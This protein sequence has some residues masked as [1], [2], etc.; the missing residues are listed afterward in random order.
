MKTVLIT[1]T[2]RGIGKALAQKFLSEGYFV[3]GTSTKGASSMLNE[4]L[5]TFQLDLADSKSI[6]NCVSKISDLKKPIDV[7]INN[8][9]AWLPEDK[10]PK[11]NIPILRK[12]LEVDLIGQIDFTERVIELLNQ[13]AHIINISSR[14]G[15]LSYPPGTG[16]LSY[17]ISKAGLNMFTRVLSHRLQGKAIISSVHPGAVKT[18][19]ASPDANMSPEEA[20][21]Y[22]YDLAV[23]KPETG[24]FWFKGEHFPW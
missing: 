14:Q 3:I 1:G 11:N 17:K 7:V 19:M 12:V 21:R 15:S 13:D 6:E 5:L 9:G 23:S 4:N 2:S 10:N 16:T 8:A 18:D 24:Q 20:A 22:I